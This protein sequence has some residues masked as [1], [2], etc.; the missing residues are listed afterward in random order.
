[1]LRQF[2]LVGRKCGGFACERARTEMISQFAEFPPP[3]ILVGDAV[4][5]EPREAS[6]DSTLLV[7]A[8]YVS[9][10]D[11][12]VSLQASSSNKRERAS[13]IGAKAA[14]RSEPT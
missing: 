10:P 11:S 9:C 12:P 8:G 3:G 1:M 2:P 5:L 4:L 7:R 6:R 13:R 14:G